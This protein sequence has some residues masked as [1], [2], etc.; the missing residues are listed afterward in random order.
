MAHENEA[1]TRGYQDEHEL[2]YEQVR[3]IMTAELL[4]RDFK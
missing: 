4:G 3:I 1:T 2:P